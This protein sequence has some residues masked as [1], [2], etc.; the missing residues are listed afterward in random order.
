MNTWLYRFTMFH[1]FEPAPSSSPASP[2]YPESS[3]REISFGRESEHLKISWLTTTVGLF[4]C[5]LSTCSNHRISSLLAEDELL[6]TAP[7]SMF[8]TR[9]L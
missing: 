9:Y 3:S 7:M 2:L 8:I 1:I 6:T 5:S 4:G